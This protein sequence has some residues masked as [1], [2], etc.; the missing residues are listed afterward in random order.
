M[1][2]R[3]AL[4]LTPVMDAKRAIDL[5]AAL[6]MVGASAVALLVNFFAVYPWL[7]EVD[8]KP[9]TPFPKLGMPAD[10]ALTIV[11][12]CAV[13]I[14]GVVLTDRSSRYIVGRSAGERVRHQ[15]SAVISTQVLSAISV[16]L[17]FVAASAGLHGLQRVG[18]S[19]KGD[20]AASAWSDLLV[21]VAVAGISWI[22]VWL[23]TANTRTPFEIE[24]SAAFDQEAA[25]LRV[26]SRVAWLKR[27]APQLPMASDE[28]I[29]K[30]LRGG[31]WSTTLGTFWVGVANFIALAVALGMADALESDYD[32]FRTLGTSV[33]LA[34]LPTA[35]YALLRRGVSNRLNG[36]AARGFGWSL[37]SLLVSLVTIVFAS[38]RG[39][40]H[41]LA[42]ALAVCM[43][44]V[45]ASVGTRTLWDKFVVSDGRLEPL[46][47]FGNGN[48]QP[49]RSIPIGLRIWSARQHLREIRISETP[50][51]AV[52]EESETSAIR[53]YL[54]LPSGWSSPI[55][56]VQDRLS[57]K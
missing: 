7:R 54:G 47:P 35:G 37:L 53:R 6:V 23:A 4:Q 45:L 22:F 12:I 19:A 25:S 10:T 26:A 39:G 2:K 52:R 30:A 14:V 49:L 46:Q 36:R 34:I 32:F 3:P 1:S 20:A 38:A 44:F 31:R 57:T 9:D 40:N 11:S 17:S 48:W 5:K 50:S 16:V 27:W 21:A 41:G 28:K 18:W 42:A 24:A 13:V 55:D 29:S 8:S 56:E 51:G 15:A 33:L 43:T